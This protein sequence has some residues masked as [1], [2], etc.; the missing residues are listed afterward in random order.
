[1]IPTRFQFGEQIFFLILP[2]T[3]EIYKKLF[4]I[5]DKDSFDG[6]VNI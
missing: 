1:M 6:I 5:E 4:N 2:Q 3:V